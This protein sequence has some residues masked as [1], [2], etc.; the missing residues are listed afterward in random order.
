MFI[1]PHKKVSFY[2]FQ[3]IQWLP[4]QIGVYNLFYVNTQI[5]IRFSHS[6]NFVSKDI[7]TLLSDKSIIK[8]LHNISSKNMPDIM[9]LRLIISECSFIIS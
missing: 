3:H 6:L 7:S 8:R 4:E 5:V 1:I 2:S 9:H